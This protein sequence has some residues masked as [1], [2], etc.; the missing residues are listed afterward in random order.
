MFELE[1]GTARVIARDVEVAD[2]ALDISTAPLEQ[3]SPLEALREAPST[4]VAN[5]A[6]LGT[7]SPIITELAARG[8]RSA[9]VE[10]L[11][12]QGQLVGLLKLASTSFDAFALE[13]RSVAREVADQLAVAL[14][15]A[16]LKEQLQRYTVEL[17][18]RVEQRT[19]QLEATN[20]ELETFSYSVSH[21]L[22]A[23]LRA[24][25]GFNQMLL[26]D[27]A[28]RLDADGR[29]FLD[30]IRTA[31]QRMGQLID[32]LLSLARVA[33]G[34]LHW[35]AVD[36]S[37]CAES[38]VAELRKAQPERQVELV[39]APRAVAQGDARLL[40]V[41]L[42]NLLSNAWKYTGKQATA[43]IELGA[44]V[45]EGQPVYFVRDDGAGFDPQY[46]DKLFAPFQRLHDS[47][48]F[49]GTGIGLATVQR[50]IHRHGG[51]LWAESAVAAGATFYFTL[52][53][54][55]PIA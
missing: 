38:I 50:I 48:E 7:P 19:A 16:Q 43:R 22:R 55:P 21:D 37:T 14:H 54:E 4:Y 34:V 35:Q 31:T 10:A 39:I 23:P 9:M 24:I 25:A 32:D 5:L 47:A 51:R 29:G 6:A 3:F 45:H 17:E 36:L 26:E 30:R 41:A 49:E 33:R 11:I 2:A 8:M 13:H 27:H 1:Q 12:A 28:E 44:S 15:D 46:A 18:R 42:E 52:A 20:R 53:A 40:R